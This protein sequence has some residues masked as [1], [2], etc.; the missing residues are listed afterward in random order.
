MAVVIF[1]VVPRYAPLFSQNHGNYYAVGTWWLLKGHFFD[2]DW[3][4]FCFFSV[5]LC[6]VLHEKAQGESASHVST[7]GKLTSCGRWL[8]TLAG[9]SLARY[10]P[11]RQIGRW[12]SFGIKRSP[13]RIPRLSSRSGSVERG[14]TFERIGSTSTRVG[15]GEK[16]C[17]CSRREGPCQHK[18]VF[19]STCERTCPSSQVGL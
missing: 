2:G 1:M 16:G 11:G 7:K 18:R 4:I 10:C 13:F 12:C 9:P 3:L 6:A 8:S 14:S 19:N 17:G 15:Q 5:S